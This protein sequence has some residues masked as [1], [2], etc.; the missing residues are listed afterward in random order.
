MTRVHWKLGLA[1][2]LAACALAAAPARNCYVIDARGQKLEGIEI[3]VT[4]PNGD[5]E[6]NDGRARFPFKAGGYKAAYIPKPD[7]L[8][9]LE[10]AYEE[11]RHED[12][13]KAAG[14]LFERY[15][16]LGW[17][18]AVAYLEGMSLLKTGKAQEAFQAFTKGKQYEGEAGAD[19]NRGVVNALLDLKDLA[20]VQ[21]MLA[22]MVTSSR[23]SDA[24][25]AF[26][27]RGRIL[28]DGGK[29]KEAV[30]EYLKVLLFFEE[31]AAVRELREDARGRAIALLKKMNDGR[32]KQ[33]E[34][35]Q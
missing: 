2:L 26:L 20:K 6:L 5:I 23:K 12:V 8:A 4:S 15:K 9:A 28:E 7:D 14:A 3:K 31:G 19:L 27:S 35:I 24:A 18:G 17:G 13:A 34:G 1:G 25:F 16:F 33:V 21:P 10:K 11:A 32:W 30:L 22:S 29:N